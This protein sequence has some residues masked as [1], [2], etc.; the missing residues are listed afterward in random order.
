VWLLIKA[1]GQITYRSASLCLE[2][3]KQLDTVAVT[4]MKTK[5]ERK[6]VQLD[7]PFV[8]AIE[9]LGQRNTSKKLW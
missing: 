5:D 4:E 1:F 7:F 9:T 8:P 3:D 2:L 6:R